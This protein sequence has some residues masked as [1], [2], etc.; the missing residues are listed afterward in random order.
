M[1]AILVKHQE[2]VIVAVVHMDTDDHRSLSVEGLLHDRSA[3]ALHLVDPPVEHD[4]S[5]LTPATSAPE[6]ETWNSV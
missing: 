4:H 2:L 1:D 6:I 5:P 3:G